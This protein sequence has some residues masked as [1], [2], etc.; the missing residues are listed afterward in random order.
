MEGKE[1]IVDSEEKV[2][3][4][5]QLASLNSAIKDAEAEL[6]EKGSTTP[7]LDFLRDKRGNLE[8]E[9]YKQRNG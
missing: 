3:I 1:K 2:D 6:E 4:A 9:L 7:D 5:T 8:T